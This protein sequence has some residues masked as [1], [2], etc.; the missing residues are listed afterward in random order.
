MSFDDVKQQCGGQAPATQ[1]R[2]GGQ[3]HPFS[4]KEADEGDAERAETSAQALATFCA[5]S[6]ATRWWRAANSCGKWL[7]C[8]GRWQRDGGLVLDA[9]NAVKFNRFERR[10]RR[11]LRCTY[12]VWDNRKNGLGDRCKACFANDFELEEH[13]G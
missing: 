6:V 10:E 7:K 13:M 2:G 11:P 9:V 4:K 3:G 8:R 5:A 12:R 1:A